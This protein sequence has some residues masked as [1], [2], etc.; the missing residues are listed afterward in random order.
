MKK[1]NLKNSKG[2]TLIA[3]VVTIIVLIILAGISISL[4]LG[5]NGIITKA[6]EARSNFQEAAEEEGTKL[7]ELYAEMNEK[8]DGQGGFGGGGSTGIDIT[9]LWPADN[10]TKPYLPDETKFHVSTK[11]EEHSLDDGI[12]IIDN[13]NNEYVWI[14]VP[15]TLEVYGSQTILDYNLDTLTGAELTSAYTTIENA[16][17]TYT[18]TYRNSADTGFADEYNSNMGTMGNIANESDYNALKQKMLKSIFENGGFYIGRYEAGLENARSTSTEGVDGTNYTTTSIQDSLKPLS[19]ANKYPLNWITC[20]QAQILANKLTTTNYSSSLMFGVQWDLVLKYIETKDN[21]ITVTFLRNNST[22]YGCY[23]NSRYSITTD[24]DVKYS[25]NFGESYTR[26]SD[27]A[28][29]HISNYS[30]LLTTGAN[31]D[32]GSNAK[33]KMQNIYDLAGNVWEY[34]LEYSMNTE[35]PCIQRGG[36]CNLRG[37]R[38][39]CF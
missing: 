17:H 35:N 4:V 3:L 15:R 18:S 36:G 2:I 37:W 11:E 13:Q 29:S 28:L 14:E 34:T 20:S 10:S 30:I 22:K 32:D 5:N 1:I 21:G 25:E 16:L 26:V 31:T 6:R 24:E 23:N 39:T 27:V 12:V 7:N 38:S 9:S 19:Q 8:I 33:F